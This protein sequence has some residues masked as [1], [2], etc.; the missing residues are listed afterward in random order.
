M[1]SVTTDQSISGKKK[2]AQNKR[3]KTLKYMWI[4]VF[5]KYGKLKHFAES[6]HQA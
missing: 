4:F 2:E 6:F 1:L 5:Q 3:G